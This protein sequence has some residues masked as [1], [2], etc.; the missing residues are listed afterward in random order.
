MSSEWGQVRAFASKPSELSVYQRDGFDYWVF[1][2]PGT[3]PLIGTSTEDYYKWGFE[4]IAIW[5]SHLDPSDG[6]IIDISPGA[7]GN[8]PPPEPGDYETFYDF[9]NGG[10][11]GSGHPVNP[12]TGLPYELQIVP[13]R[14]YARVLAE[15]WA[16]GPDS[17]TPPGH[18]FTIA[19]YVSDHPQTVKRLGGVG[20][21]LDDLEWDVKV[22]LALSGAMHD[23]AVSAW[24][25]KGSYDYVRPISA[26]RYMSDLGQSSEPG[27]SGAA[28]YDPRELRL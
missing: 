24:G 16:D 19:N 25:A 7:I 8:S 18:W 17:E 5:S 3:P 14:D 13:R 9:L 15:F 10:D 23:A 27:G 4:M 2:D 6:V 11:S 28:A 26:L 22:Y 20:R 12:V 21:V 1:H